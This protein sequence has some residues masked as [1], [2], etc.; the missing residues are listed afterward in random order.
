MP[1]LSSGEARAD[2]VDECIVNRDGNDCRGLDLRED[3]E[4]DDREDRNDRP[5]WGLGKS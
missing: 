4:R 2:E 3:R 5:D 1:V